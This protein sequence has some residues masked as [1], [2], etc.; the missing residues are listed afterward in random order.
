MENARLLGELRQRTGDLEES[1]EYQTAVSDVLKV[2]SQSGT[3]LGAVLD[4]LVGTAARIC[5]ADSG[6]IFRLDGGLHRM[7]AAFGI[8]SEYRDFQARNPIG[9]G[10]GTLAGRTALVRRAVHIEANCHWLVPIWYLVE[11]FFC[12]WHSSSLKTWSE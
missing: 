11:Q 4:T 8:P 3:E 9:P 12:R 6:F 7:I 5:W 10:R 2:I 1:L